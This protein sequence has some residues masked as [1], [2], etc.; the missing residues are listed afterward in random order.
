MNRTEIIEAW[1]REERQPLLGWDFSYLN[2]RMT[3]GQVS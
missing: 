1:L 3:E 2:G